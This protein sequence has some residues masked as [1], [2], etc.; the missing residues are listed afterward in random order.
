MTNTKNDVNRAAYR[1]PE[2]ANI[3]GISISLM[4]KM[5]RM[6]QVR[7]IR[8]GERGVLISRAEIERLVSGNE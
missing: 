7:T 3:L 5:I 1:R 6:G 8:V 2:A 4:D